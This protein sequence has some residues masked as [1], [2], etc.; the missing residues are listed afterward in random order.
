MD[1]FSEAFPGA[2]WG[3]L[4]E[5]RRR[6][7]QALEGA[8]RSRPGGPFE[9]LSIFWILTIA[10]MQSAGSVSNLPIFLR[11]ATLRLHQG[12]GNQGGRPLRELTS[13]RKASETIRKGI[14]LR[15]V[16]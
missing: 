10:L 13:N 16:S 5:M 6:F 7:L 2:R 4:E 14:I 8:R 1:D 11:L 9:V 15:R 3:S 12:Y